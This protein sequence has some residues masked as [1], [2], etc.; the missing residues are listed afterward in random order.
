VGDDGN[1]IH[2]SGDSMVVDPLGE[3]LYSK[4]QEEDVFTLTLQKERLDE[5]RNKFPFWK[6]ADS[7]SILP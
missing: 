3:I 6:D 2:Y 1:N 4:T 7:F 5:V